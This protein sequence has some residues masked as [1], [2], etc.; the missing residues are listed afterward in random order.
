MVLCVR[1][2]LAIR[3]LVAWHETEDPLEGQV[4]AWIEKDLF[5][6]RKYAA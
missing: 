3:D 4:G 2:Q 1:I 5:H 6:E